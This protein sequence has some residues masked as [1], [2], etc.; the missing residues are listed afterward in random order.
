M[1]LW[2]RLVGVH[3][4]KVTFAVE[5]LEELANLSLITTQ[6][7]P[8][9]VLQIN[10]E[11]SISPVQRKKAYAIMGDIAK[12]SGYTP[13]ELKDWMKFYFEEETGYPYFS[14]AN[15]DMTTARQFISFLIGYAL[16]FHVPLSKPAMEYQDDLD[17]YMFQTLK[18]RRC[19][20]CGKHADVHHIDTVGMGND[21]KLVDH[22]NKRL[23]ALCREHHNEAHNRGWTSFADLYHVKGITLDPETLNRLGIM[24]YKRMREIDEKAGYHGTTKN[25]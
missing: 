21:R 20:L 24:T 25:D 22:R 18:F 9:A 5:N 13:E 4:N 14:F 6:D 10:D 12:W 17:A 19:V 8:E 15:T 16:K 1:N 2:G 11:R 3:G 23:I 7:R